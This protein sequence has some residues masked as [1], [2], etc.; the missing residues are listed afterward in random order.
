MR[1]ASGVFWNGDDGLAVQLGGGLRKV[2][3]R[4]H[5]GALGFV[6]LVEHGAKLRYVAVQYNSIWL[7]ALE[8]NQY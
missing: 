1:C 3:K 5:Q 6:D 8:W 2:G 4:L 7:R